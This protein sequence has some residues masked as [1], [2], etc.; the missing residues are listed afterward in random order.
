MADRKYRGVPITGFSTTCT[1]LTTVVTVNGVP[2]EPQEQEITEK[3]QLNG[4]VTF[5]L[6][7]P[8]GFA[9][10][11]AVRMFRSLTTAGLTNANE[12]VIMI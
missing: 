7:I 6:P 10:W 12:Y 4:S 8:D 5:I 3:D 11:Y 2:N 9:F 1:H